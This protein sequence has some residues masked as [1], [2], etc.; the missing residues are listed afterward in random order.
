MTILLK[1]AKMQKLSTK[2][3]YTVELTDKGIEAKLKRLADG[4]EKCFLIRGHS[5]VQAI[6]SHFDSLTDILCEELIKKA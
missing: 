5:N 1:K 4:K 6:K 2:F 3:E